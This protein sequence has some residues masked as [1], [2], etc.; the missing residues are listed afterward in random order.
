M[1]T[2]MRVLPNIHLEI[3]SDRGAD[4]DGLIDIPPSVIGATVRWED[5]YNNVSYENTLLNTHSIWLLDI[6]RPGAK[7][8]KYY[9]RVLHALSDLTPYILLG[10]GGSRSD[11]YHSII[12]WISSQYMDNVYKTTE[13]KTLS[14]TLRKVLGSNREE[15]I[16]A[17]NLSIRGLEVQFYDGE[18]HVT[19][20]DYLKSLLGRID[21]DVKNISIGRDRTFITIHFLDGS[22]EYIPS[23]MLRAGA[24]RAR[25]EHS[26]AAYEKSA[27]VIGERIRHFRR[28]TGLTQSELGAMIGKSRHAVMRFES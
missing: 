7:S 23:D 6:F 5:L 4:L 24:S 27:L 2:T 16:H 17:I 19:A 15:L 8:I 26:R 3:V 18:I 10:G 1:E 11:T 20:I 28:K 14:N 25:M 21:H 22:R 13:A 9:A 12:S